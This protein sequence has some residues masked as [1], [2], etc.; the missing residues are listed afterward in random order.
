MEVGLVGGAT[1]NANLTRGTGELL[2]PW[3]RFA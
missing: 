2:L 1:Y 3:G